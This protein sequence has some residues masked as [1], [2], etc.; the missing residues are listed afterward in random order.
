MSTKVEGDSKV[1]VTPEKVEDQQVQYASEVQE[2]VSRYLPDKIVEKYPI[3]EELGAYNV[4]DLMNVECEDLESVFLEDLHTKIRFLPLEIKHILKL[5]EWIDTLDD[6]GDW[7][8][9]SK[10]DFESW[11]R[12]NR[13]ATPVQQLSQPVVQQVSKV[14]SGSSNDFTKKLKISVSDY[15]ELTN[16]DHFNNWVEDFTTMAGCHRIDE[17]VTEDFNPTNP[18]DT[19]FIYKNTFLYNVLHKMVKT[20]RGKVITREFYKTKSGDDCFAALVRAYNQGISKELKSDELKEA[21]RNFKLTDSWKGAYTK[22]MDNWKHKVMDLE[23]LEPVKEEDKRTWLLAALETHN[24]LYG[25][26][27]QMRVFRNYAGKDSAVEESFDQLF[28]LFYEQARLL[29]KRKKSD[30]AKEKEKEKEEPKKRHVNTHERKKKDRIPDDKWK[31]M[32]PG[33][34]R[35]EFQKR[36]IWDPINNNWHRKLEEQCKEHGRKIKANAALREINQHTQVPPSGNATNNPT[37]APNLRNL[38]SPAAAPGALARHMLSANHANQQGGQQT[39]M[40][41]TVGNHTY[42]IVGNHNV[43]YRVSPHATSK[44]QGSLI[45]G[46]ANGGICGTDMR[47]MGTT[48]KKADVTG[49]KDYTVTELDIVHGTAVIKLKNKKKIIGHFFQYAD[50]GSG[51]S[52]HST[53][54]L[55][56]FGLTVDTTS[57]ARGGKQQII[58]PNGHVIPLSIRNGLAQMDMKKPTDEELEN[59]NIEHVYFTSDSDWDPSV[60]DCEA[61]Y[62][63]DSDDP[64]EKGEITCN[65]H[66]IDP[67]DKELI[68]CCEDMYD[69]IINSKDEDF[70]SYVDYCIL[71]ANT[72]RIEKYF[73]EEDPVR[74]VHNRRVFFKPKSIVPKEPDYEKLRPFLGWIRADRVKATLENTTQWYRQEKRIPMRKH[75]KSRFPAGNVPHLNDTVSH[76]TIISDTPAADDGIAG[77]AGC[78]IAEL[79]ACTSSALMMLV[80]MSDYTEMPQA[81]QDFIRTHGAPNVLMS[82]NAKANIS[83]RLIDVLRFYNIYGQTSTPHQQNQNPV[84]RKIQDV[85]NFT[86]ILMDRTFT[87][88]KYWL[89]CMLFVIGLMNVLAQPL[90]ENKTAIELAKGYKPDISPYLAHRWWEPVYFRDEDR[91]FPSKSRERLGRWCGPAENCGDILTFNIL[92]AETGYI[93]KKAE[94]RSALDPANVNLRAEFELFES[95]EGEG[96]DALPDKN[97]K[98]RPRLK[99][100]SQQNLPASQNPAEIRLPQFSPAELLGMTFLKQQEDGTMIRAKVTKKINDLDAENHENIKMLIEVGDEGGYEELI[101]YLDL[102]DAIE[103]QHRLEKENPNAHWEFVDIV[104]HTGPLKKGD[105]G[106]NGSMYNIDILWGNGET[107]PEPLNVFAKDDPITCAKYALKHGLLDLPGWRRFRRLAKREQKMKRM[108]KH[109]QAFNAR[110]GPV[111]MFGIQVP[112]SIAEAKRLDEENRNTLWQDAIKKEMDQ[113]KE[114]KTFRKLERGSQ[115]PEGYIGI[116]LQWVFAVKHDGRR[117]ARD[118]C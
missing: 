111:Y 118:C 30:K 52:I 55:E 102:C 104:G 10:S 59:P 7:K 18:S 68:N 78:E 114:Y 23:A 53:G 103:E 26:R 57:Q 19:E 41:L 70:E 106:Y 47:V 97:S 17:L 9:Q 69:S 85:K 50:M 96:K 66:D 79:F 82:D 11:K 76:D 110:R 35:A 28:A 99:S 72:K 21:V 48:G 94:C 51:K 95:V 60:L 34:K 67:Y 108:A 101:G 98:L 45:D 14:S 36:G 89:L 107:T 63:G 24:E 3:L 74:E 13:K 49:I 115:A 88:A 4:E 43:I 32:H 64:P 77:H 16:D 93:V 62:D 75:Y 58:T 80:P 81:L 8:E 44:K 22:F 100:V 38:N 71:H 113:L 105:K 1:S 31:A 40:T 117:K 25:V 73:D 6:Q 29:D 12:E 5:V 92:D 15:K 39:E 56:A 86:D 65:I 91:H 116:T 90:K 61:Q 2:L 33:Q 54:Q 109:I 83:A 87:P 42:R 37:S 20:S 46:G 112:Q 84:E 27:N